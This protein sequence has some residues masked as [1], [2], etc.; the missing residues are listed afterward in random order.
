MF[1]LLIFATLKRSNE[2]NQNVHKHPYLF[3]T[4]RQKGMGDLSGL[5]FFLIVLVYIFITKILSR[6]TFPHFSTFLFRPEADKIILPA[7]IS[8]R[9][10]VKKIFRSTKILCSGLL[11][12]GTWVGWMLEVSYV[13]IRH[14]FKEG[15]CQYSI[16]IQHK[17]FLT[18][19]YPLS[20]L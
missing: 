18:S 3:L 14:H 20:E 8:L 4:T 19:K 13:E 15:K 17:K 5:S 7:E 16:N 9:G 6:E 12:T 11:L 10:I 1:L 2:H